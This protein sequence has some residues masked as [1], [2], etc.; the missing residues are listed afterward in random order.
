[1]S[2]IKSSNNFGCPTPT[3]KNQ[4]RNPNYPMKNWKTSIFGT[5]GILIIAAN[6]ASMLLDGNPATNPDWG[7]TFAALMP[8]FAAMFA[9]DA[10]VTS[11]DMGLK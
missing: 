8:S 1:M 6:V 9:R 4:T 7:V 11:K 10:T 3:L 5:G 2:P